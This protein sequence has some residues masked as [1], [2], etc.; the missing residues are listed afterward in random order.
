MNSINNNLIVLTL[1]ISVFSVLNLNAQQGAIPNS[2]TMESYVSMGDVQVIQSFDLRY[3]GVKGTPFLYED[4]RDGHVTL[5]GKEDEEPR[6][7]KMNI[8]LLENQLFVV[9]YD[10]TVGPLPS[11]FVKDINFKA[12]TEEESKE[13]KFVPMIRKLV[14]GINNE[15]LGY[16][17]LIYEGDMKVLKHI[18]KT[19]KE[20]DYKG[21]YSS[22]IRY[23]E[24]KQ[25]TRYFV[26]ADGI[27]FVKVK[28][29]TKNLEKA[30]PKHASEIRGIIKKGKLNL[31]KDEDIKTLFAALAK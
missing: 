19:F 25:D 2:G 9:L 6:T 22:D 24:Y 4:W 30:F 20:A 18:R 3:E 21:A 14:E 13:I 26:S 8:N 10:G 11:K 7:F 29:K 16:Y 1:F 28:M 17:Q 15:T 31:S 5:R 23:D 12:D 27:S